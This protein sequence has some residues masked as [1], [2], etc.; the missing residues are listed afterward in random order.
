MPTGTTK[1]EKRGVATALPCWHSEN[2]IQCNMCSFVCP[3]GAIRP[4]L[5]KVSDADNAPNT[6]STLPAMLENKYKFVVQVSPEDCTGCGVCANTCPAKVKALTMV[7]AVDIHDK[8][9]SNYEYLSKLPILHSQVFG[10]NT[11]KGSQF[12]APYF[13][14]SGACAGCGETPYIKV[15]SQLFGERMVIANATGCSSIYGGSSPTI[16][17][18][19]DEHGYGP[20]WANS[21]FEDNAEFGLG[22][23]L[24]AQENHAK[25]VKAVNNLKRYN[26]TKDISF[27]FDEQDTHTLR[28]N[29]A[30]LVKLLNSI[31]SPT[32]ALQQ[33]IDTINTLKNCFAKDSV[34][35][36]GGDG[37]AYDIGYG[38]LDHILASGANVNVLVLDT[39][40]YSNTGGQASKATPLGSVA[41]FASLGKRTNKKDL[42]MM[43]MN[44]KNVYVAKV[45]IGANMNQYI[46][47]LTEAEKY[48]GPS[49]IIAYAPCINH[50]LAMSE[51]IMEEKRAVD[52]G[53]WHLFRYNPDNLGTNKP[54][55]ILDSAKPTMKYEDFLAG[56]T[57]YSSLLKSHPEI[58]TKLFKLASD[59]ALAKH[60]EYL[61]LSKK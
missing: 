15:L 22:I 30:N 44:Y 38:G 51:S 4:R 8:E 23:Y 16:P 31:N 53:Y 10:R 14:F 25:L 46:S 9:V 7:Q 49:L 35:I 54:V 19:K 21:L 55:F 45:A 1:Y 37:W 17:Y 28:K 18:T 48:D 39:E 24:G 59:N 5:I 36:I 52:S 41:K 33:T 26:Q 61:E 13:E 40:V 6:L 47:A 11:V 29:G 58:A 50:G 32:P 60:E 42:A 27:D 12:V 34:W 43:A 20:A 3:H 2:C 56:E 57:R